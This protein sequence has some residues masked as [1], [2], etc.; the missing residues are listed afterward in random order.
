MIRNS[1]EPCLTFEKKCFTIFCCTEKQSYLTSCVTKVEQFMIPC[2]KAQFNAL[3]N[4]KRLENPP[5]L[6]N[7]Q[8]E[9]LMSSTT[10]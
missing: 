6:P 10:T 5:P 7:T 9:T 1:W 3:K 2:Q 8:H 4:K